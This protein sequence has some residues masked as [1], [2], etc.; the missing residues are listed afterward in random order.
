MNRPRIRDD[1][2]SLWN[3]IAI[4][5]VIF[6]RGVSESASDDGTPTLDFGDESSH[7]G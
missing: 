2:R 6:G 1:G 7:V 4:V 5:D 3:E